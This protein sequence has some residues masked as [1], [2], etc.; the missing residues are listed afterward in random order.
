LAGHISK[1]NGTRN[2]EVIFIVSD[3]IY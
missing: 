3:D 2:G 1:N